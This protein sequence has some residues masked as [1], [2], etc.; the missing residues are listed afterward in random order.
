PSVGGAA[1]FVKV[2][3]SAFTQALTQRAVR[4]G[5]PIVQ[6][7]VIFVRFLVLWRGVLGVILAFRTVWGDICTFLVVLGR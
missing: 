2:C 3:V 4:V 5:T 6:K 7:G 1:R